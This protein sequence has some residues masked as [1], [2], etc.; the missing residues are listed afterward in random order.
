MNDIYQ[1]E[2]EIPI[3]AIMHSTQGLL[4][5]VSALAAK[6]AVVRREAEGDAAMNVDGSTDVSDNDFL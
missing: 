1:R 4:A 3:E 5:E 6:G 2:I